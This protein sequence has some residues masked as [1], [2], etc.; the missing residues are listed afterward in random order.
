[1]IRAILAAFAVFFGGRLDI[2]LEVLAPRQQVAV[3]KRKRHRP[4][5]N[6]LD[7]WFWIM[8]RSVWPRWWDAL[9]IVKPATVIAWHRKGFRLF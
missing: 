6:R 5:L 2:S 9:A 7:R 4:V 8:L 3:L 1:M